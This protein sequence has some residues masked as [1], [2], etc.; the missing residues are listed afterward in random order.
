MA[1]KFT[2]ESARRIA[3]AVR[4][5]E[6]SQTTSAIRRGVP[7]TPQWDYVLL[8]KT[9]TTSSK[10][11]ETEIAVYAGETA[12]TATATGDTV[13]AYNRFGTIQANKWVFVWPMPWGFEISAAEC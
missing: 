9:Q 6:G 13:T 8:G 11:A 2:P 1:T 10:N 4:A 12:A 3:R 5:V 7:Q